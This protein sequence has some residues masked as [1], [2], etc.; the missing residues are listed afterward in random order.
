VP[1]EAPQEPA[2]ELRRLYVVKEWHGRGVAAELMQW[3]LGEA[4]AAG[5][6]WLYLGVWRHNA[7]AQ[8]FYA[9]YGL[10]KVGEYLFR[11][12]THLDE[13]DILRVDLRATAPR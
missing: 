10:R 5:A 9:R 2:L 7:R 3:C 4:R 6:A 12:G 1:I 11:V 13:E 8:R